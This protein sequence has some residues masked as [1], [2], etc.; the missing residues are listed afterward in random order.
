MRRIKL[1]MSKAQ[2]PLTGKMSGSMGN[3]V[4]STLGDQNIVRSKAFQPHDANSEAQKM[5]RKGFK[6]IV[7]VY[8]I[9]GGIPDEGFVQRNENT[10]AFNAFIKANLSTAVNKSGNST[11]IDYSKLVVSNG[12]LP[13]LSVTAFSLDATG[14]MVTYVPKQNLLTNLPTDIVVA[15]ALLKTGELWIER[16]TRGSGVIAT[17]LIPVTNVSAVDIQAV[18]LFVKR[19]DG[20]KTSV[21]TY[22]NV[23]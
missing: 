1:T 15:I 10:T 13:K 18:Y 16:Q 3:F 6:M 20:S 8:T 21:S 2:N 14:I 17:V 9:L 19:A 5:Q 7:E 11:V 4:T 22:L 23:G 12:S